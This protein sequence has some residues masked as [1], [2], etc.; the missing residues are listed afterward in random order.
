MVWEAEATIT[1]DTS[2]LTAVIDLQQDDSGN[3]TWAYVNGI[4]NIGGRRM[5][6]WGDRIKWPSTPGPARWG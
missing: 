6:T 3:K 2:Q 4:L 1:S 5:E